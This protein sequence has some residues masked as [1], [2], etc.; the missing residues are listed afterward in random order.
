MKTFRLSEKY[1]KHYILIG[2]GFLIC[3]IFIYTFRI[4][5]KFMG[6]MKF[7]FYFVSLLLS[8]MYLFRH[9][10][11][12]IILTE[13]SI[14]YYDGIAPKKTYVFKNIK[15]VEYG[16][17]KKIRVH[18]IGRRIVAIPY[19][20]NDLDTFIEGLKKAKVKVVKHDR[21]N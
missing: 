11:N 12:K 19:V 2:S 9:K 7:L 17:K 1:K 20:F 4:D 3:S 18:L 13:K 6:S 16:F 14:I 5:Y 10:I 8:F 21:Y 15:Q